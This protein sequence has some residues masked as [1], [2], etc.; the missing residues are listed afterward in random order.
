MGKGSTVRPSAV[1]I[2]TYHANFDRIFGGGNKK[3]G[4]DAES[5]H[6]RDGEPKPRKRGRIQTG[7][8]ENGGRDGSGD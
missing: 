6:H 8:A 7:P 5:G 2:E 3:P 1:D 4:A